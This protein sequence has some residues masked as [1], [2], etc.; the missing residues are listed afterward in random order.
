MKTDT[1]TG[2][3]ARLTAFIKGVLIMKLPFGKMTRMLE[4]KNSQDILRNIFRDTLTSSSL[5]AFLMTPSIYFKDSPTIV[6]LIILTISTFSCLF[7]LSWV[8]YALRP[9][10]EELLKRDTKIHRAC[11][12]IWIVLIE[13]GISFSISHLFISVIKK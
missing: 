13:F 5:I 10:F 1:Y 4:E 12:A 8:I 9:Q 3:Y 7:V 11:F 2:L 6:W